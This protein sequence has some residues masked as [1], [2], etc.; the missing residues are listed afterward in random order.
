MKKCT[1]ALIIITLVLF[2]FAF[3][4]GNMA[5][6]ANTATQ[7]VTCEIQA[8]DELSVS[9]DPAPL[10][11]SSAAAGSE[12]T[13]ATDSSTTY[14]IT[15]NQAG[16]KITGQIDTDMTAGTLTVNLTAPTGG[17]STGNVTLSSVAAD[18]VTGFGAVAE[19]T[20]TITYTFSATASAGV[21]AST[22][23]TVTLTLIGM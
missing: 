4:I 9:G 13:S 7:T 15:T 14:S 16:R 5:E 23:K 19:G 11:I 20:R 8:I 1:A 12:P 2:V 3:G 18:L 17:T 21:A 6:A 22:T 10:I